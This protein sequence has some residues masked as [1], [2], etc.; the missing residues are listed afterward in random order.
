M[1]DLNEEIRKLG[2]VQID[3]S[4]LALG[5]LGFLASGMTGAAAGLIAVRLALPEMQP[6]GVWRT[7]V[8]LAVLC[9]PLAGLCRIPLHQLDHRPVQLG[10]HAVLAGGIMV[11]HLTWWGWPGTALLLAGSYLLVVI[12]ARRRHR[13]LQQRQTASGRTT[14]ANQAHGSVACCS[15][16]PHNLCAPVSYAGCACMPVGARQCACVPVGAGASQGDPPVTAGG[17]KPEETLFEPS[18]AIEL[19]SRNRGVTGSTSGVAG[20]APVEPV[21]GDHVECS[22]F[23]PP[24]TRAGDQLLV[25][26][27]AH[28]PEQS[29]EAAAMARQ[30][31]ADSTRRGLRTLEK[32]I[33]RGTPLAFHLEIPTLIVDGPIQTLVWSGRAESVQF[34]VTVPPGR[35]PGNAVGTVTVSIRS[36][37]VGHIK[38][39]LKV[40][41]DQASERKP[42]PLGDQAQA[43]SMA[44]VSYA[45]AD[46]AKVIPRV[47]MLRAVGID[48]FQDILDL[49]PGARWEQKLYERIDS[50]DLFLLFWSSAA[51]ESEWVMREVQY[52]LK[53][54]GGD[55][56]A[57]P[58][59]RPVIIEGPPIVPPPEVP[60]APSF[61]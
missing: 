47:Q 43:Y 52:A 5:C 37:P 17:E 51:K 40:S 3:K 32:V 55:D 18:E 35:R 15:C 28:C 23:A 30:F 60:G 42:V 8:V 59:I 56:L 54:K 11:L 27:F 14:T 44:F 46:R 50:C 41:P 10:L 53:R 45:A 48:Y 49:E 16:N 34:G 29:A 57:P 1:S 38:F 12:A 9:L 31:D 6:S 25:Q 33:A 2:G 24:Q 58:E 61:Q 36:I 7:G 19:L 22:V 13:A 20:N 39:T 21:G 4:A 26:V